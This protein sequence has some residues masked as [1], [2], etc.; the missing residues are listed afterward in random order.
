MYSF[1]IDKSRNPTDGIA[2]I[3]HQKPAGAFPMSKSLIEFTVKY[4]IN[5][6]VERTNPHG[7]IFV[8][9]DRKH[10]KFFLV[11]SRSYFDNPHS[12]CSMSRGAILVIPLLIRLGNIILKR[13]P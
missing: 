6:L 1:L 5:V 13:V 7:L 11:I 9:P 12:C 3:V 2:G 4:G 8:E 10:Y